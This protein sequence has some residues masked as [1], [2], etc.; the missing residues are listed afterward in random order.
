MATNI[1][2]QL[3]IPPTPCSSGKSRLGWYRILLSTT[4]PKNKSR[5]ATL[6]LSESPPMKDAFSLPKMVPAPSAQGD[7]VSLS[8]QKMTSKRER[9]S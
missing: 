5:A 2:H 3:A 8:V 7:L 4:E 6:L 1:T 9:G